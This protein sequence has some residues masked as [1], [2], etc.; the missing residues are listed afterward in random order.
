[1]ELKTC[2]DDYVLG[3]APKNPPTKGHRFNETHTCP[4]C[5]KRIR[6]TFERVELLGAPDEFAPIAAE[7]V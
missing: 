3:A 4:K 6:I 5:K 7:Y 1:M 2:C